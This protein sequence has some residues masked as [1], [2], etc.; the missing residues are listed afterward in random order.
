MLKGA[1]QSQR[2]KFRTSKNSPQLAS[3]NTSSL[4]SPPMS[5]GRKSLRKPEPSTAEKQPKSQGP[6]LEPLPRAS[7]KTQQRPKLY[8][9]RSQVILQSLEEEIKKDQNTY[10]QQQLQIMDTQAILQHTSQKNLKLRESQLWATSRRKQSRV[11]V[12]DNVNNIN[13]IINKIV[14]EKGLIQRRKQLGELR[15]QVKVNG[16]FVFMK[17]DGSDQV[18]RTARAS[19]TEDTAQFLGLVDRFDRMKNR[20]E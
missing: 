14:K 16:K 13:A 4:V 6:K 7:L 2:V 12:A 19:P 3:L 18:V 15:T 20:G 11:S 1:P 8:Q 9:N 5:P 17:Q 10:T